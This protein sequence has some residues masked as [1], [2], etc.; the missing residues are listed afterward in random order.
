V[1]CL[2]AGCGRAANNGP[3][4]KDAKPAPAASGVTMAVTIN[5]LV[6]AEGEELTES[7]K[8]YN[9]PTPALIEEKFNA[10]AWADAKL[11]PTVGMTRSDKG[12]LQSTLKIGRP[13]DSKATKAVQAEWI[14]YEKN[15]MHTSPLDT[16]ATGL[17]LLKAYLDGQKIDEMVK[18]TKVE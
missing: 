17:K 14:L 8:I 4:E 7:M 18:W 10:V 9:D 16:P 1:L 11:R 13:R 5:K 6:S 15:E 2:V 12:R 3:S